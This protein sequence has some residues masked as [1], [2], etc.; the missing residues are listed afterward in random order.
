MVNI[1]LLEYI[2]QQ[3][4]LNTD[5]EAV[6]RNLVAS[7][8]WSIQ[9]IDQAFS[10]L[11]SGQKPSK[12]T[13]LALVVVVV[14]CVVGG[15]YVFFK[16]APD[17]KGAFVETVDSSAAGPSQPGG[18]YYLYT[19]PAIP[20]SLELPEGWGVADRDSEGEYRKQLDV[21]TPSESRYVEYSATE[22]AVLLAKS[23]IQISIVT[24]T[25]DNR[26][27]IWSMH[28]SGGTRI[29]VAN[30]SEPV[31]EVI[32]FDSQ[33]PLENCTGAGY[34]ILTTKRIYQIAS[35][36]KNESDRG[37]LIGHLNRIVQTLVERE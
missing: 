19:N 12:V 4:A 23:Y 16:K 13:L 6:K 32:Q 25:E 10:A 2:K 24:P 34:A 26:A 7:G 20:Y 9:D 18:G 36:S 14:L 22:Q 15:I 31:R 28:T 5:R 1:Q 3:L 21:L 27:K 8:G 30:A 37:D 29:E 11:S 17:E 33:G 35:C